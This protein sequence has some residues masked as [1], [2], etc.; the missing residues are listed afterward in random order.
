L[1]SFFS[2]FLASVFLVIRLKNLQ[3]KKIKTIAAKKKLKLE[4]WKNFFS[5]LKT[6]TLDILSK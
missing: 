4:D 3:N 6:R 2:I 1:V 5:D